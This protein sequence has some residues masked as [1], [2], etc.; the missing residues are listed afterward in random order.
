MHAAEHNDVRARLGRLLRE[1]ERIADVIRHV[2][3]FRHLIIVGE[4]DG[5]EL[6]FERKNFPGQRLEPGVRHR[7]ADLQV[8]HDQG[9]TISNF[10]HT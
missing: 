1:P 4:D 6:L 2:L 7:R 10:N 8:V 5:V 3:D 9:G